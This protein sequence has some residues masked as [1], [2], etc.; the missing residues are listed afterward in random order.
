MGRPK[1]AGQADGKALQGTHHQEGAEPPGHA[2]RSQLQ[3]RQRVATISHLN[4][5]HRFPPGPAALGSLRVM[6]GLHHDPTAVMSGLHDEYGDLVHFRIGPQHVYVVLRAD[7]VR[8]VLVTHGKSFKKGPGFERARI[9]L[10]NGLLTSEG[11]FH[12]RQRRMLQPAFHRRRIAS[13]A[14]IMVDEAQR[15]SGRMR[16]DESRDVAADMSQLALRVVARAL[17]GAEL[18][19]DAL[20][21]STRLPR[22]ASS[23][24]T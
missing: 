11:D 23:S 22:W 4:G 14:G 16:E 6:T 8:Q 9:V 5:R 24:T 10:G 13:Y 21:I 2:T 18:D 3:S 15:L 20:E 1:Q 19:E 12:L 17:F 7:L